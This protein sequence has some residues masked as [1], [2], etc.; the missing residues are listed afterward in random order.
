[1]LISELQ[2]VKAAT[3]F[4]IW[5]CQDLENSSNLK[6]SRF[7]IQDSRLGCYLNPQYCILNYW[8]LKNASI[9]W[10]NTIL[11]SSDVRISWTDWNIASWNEDLKILEY[12]MYV[13]CSNH[14]QQQL[15]RNL[16]SW[17]LPS[18]NIARCWDM[19]IFQDYNVSRL[20]NCKN[21]RCQDLEI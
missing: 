12:W 11:N 4:K 16:E 13:V 2:D 15:F 1:M 9:S 18:F 3:R 10:N 8:I 21:S 17:K 6:M 19:W 5:S 20:H 7:T 14:I